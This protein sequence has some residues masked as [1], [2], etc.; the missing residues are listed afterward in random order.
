MME[1]MECLSHVAKRMKT[2]LCKRQENILKDSRTS[3]AAANRFYQEKLAMT[4]RE[5][6][7][8]LKEYAGNLY[9]TNVPRD[10]W[11]SGTSLPIKQLSN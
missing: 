7:K 10:Y 6:R 11:D 4:E 1:H 3:K 8:E 2:N 9:R 5:V